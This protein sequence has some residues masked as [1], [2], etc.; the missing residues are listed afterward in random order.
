MDMFH[1]VA[2]GLPNVWLANGYTTGVSS[3]G[4]PIFH[5]D[6][7]EELHKAI[8]FSLV[9]KDTI[10]TGDEFR[11]LRSEIK[12]TRKSLAGILAYSEEAIKKWESGENPIQKTADVTLRNLYLES[13]NRASE[14]K[15]L[16]D[17]INHLEKKHTQLFFKEGGSGWEPDKKC[18]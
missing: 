11:F 15:N 12:L 17:K 2:C 16:L 7:V 3:D 8:A 4:D 18:A 9:E 10:L 6:N 5:V 14:V 13:Q 1:Y